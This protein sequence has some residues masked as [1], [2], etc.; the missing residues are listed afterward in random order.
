MTTTKKEKLDDWKVGLKEKETWPDLKY[1]FDHSTHCVMLLNDESHTYD[2]VTTVIKKALK[3][4]EKKASELTELVDKEGRAIVK[5]DEYKNC[6]KIQDVVK[7][8]SSIGGSDPL[9][10]RVLPVY[11]IAHQQF[12]VRL[13]TWLE[14][15]FS[16]CSGKLQKRKKIRES[17]HM[18][19]SFCLRSNNPCLR[20][21]N[22]C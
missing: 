7:A 12:A 11:L 16:K 20:S 1:M 6:L 22:P 19:I 3:H 14:E 18:T 21:S 8:N 5:V 13:C 15:L 10:V 2:Q 17:R 4:P 9:N